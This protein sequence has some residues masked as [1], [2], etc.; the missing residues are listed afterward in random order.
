MKT[1]GEATERLASTGTALLAPGLVHLWVGLVAHHQPRALACCR[2][3]VCHARCAAD[4]LACCSVRGCGARLAAAT[5]FCAAAVTAAS[6]RTTRGTMWGR[7]ASSMGALRGAPPP[8]PP[9]LLLLL[10]C[11]WGCRCAGMVG[12]GC[13]CWPSAGEPLPTWPTP[14]CLPHL[15]TLLAACLNPPC[16]P[17]GV[18]HR[19]SPQARRP[20]GS[21]VCAGPAVQEPVWAPAL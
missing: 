10:A 3:C 11:C 2:C 15:V 9:L 5:L 7:L 21:Q 12:G 20:H 1:H 16:W 14:P 18:P 4:I 8:P 17:P 13:V 6:T 19:H